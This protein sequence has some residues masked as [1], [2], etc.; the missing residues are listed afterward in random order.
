MRRHNGR[1]IGAFEHAEGQH[2]AT[3]II[4]TGLKN[5]TETLNNLP[6]G[7]ANRHYTKD[8]PNGFPCLNQCT[9]PPP[10]ACST[11]IVLSRR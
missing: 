9:T 2:R 10:N 4:D 11:M 7:Q 8:E 3:T 6:P 1:T 5:G